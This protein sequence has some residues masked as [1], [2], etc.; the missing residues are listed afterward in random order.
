LAVIRQ[1]SLPLSISTLVRFTCQGRHPTKA[2]NLVAIDDRFVLNAGQ[3]V[4]IRTLETINLPPSLAAFGFPPSRVSGQWILM[5]NPGHI[6]PGYEGHLHLTAINMGREPF[7]IRKGDIIVTLVVVE[8]ATPPK[9]DFIARYGGSSPSHITQRQLDRLSPDFANVQERATV[10]A[11]KAVQAAEL[12]IK[13]AQQ[14]VQNLGIF[15]RPIRV[16][17]LS[18]KCIDKV[19]LRGICYDFHFGPAT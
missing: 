8:L 5:T 15:G 18:V 2:G 19:V 6:D 13:K 10:V 17:V 9:A 16:G 12:S 3:T 14:P 4:V 7:E 1:F 11:N